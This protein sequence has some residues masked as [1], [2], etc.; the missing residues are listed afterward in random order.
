MKRQ[1]VTLTAAVVCDRCG[2]TIKAGE[3][4]IVTF[5]EKT[6]E[7][8]FTHEACPA[9]EN[10]AVKVPRP[11]RPRTLVRGAVRARTVNRRK[12]NTN[13]KARKVR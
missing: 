9:A 12:G 13:N 1:R 3:T 8:R 7:C 5:D 11:I 10:A 4:A 2:E 6:G